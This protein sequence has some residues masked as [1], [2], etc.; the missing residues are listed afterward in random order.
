MNSIPYN[1]RYLVGLG[2]FLLGFRMAF[3]DYG[4]A[5]LASFIAGLVICFPVLVNYFK[6][7]KTVRIS[8]PW[9]DIPTYI[10]IG[11]I[12]KGIATLACLLIVGGFQR[13][14]YKESIA[15]AVICAIILSP[16]D[17]LLFGPPDPYQP[18]RKTVRNTI[19]VSIRCAG[20]GLYLMGLYHLMEDKHTKQEVAMSL[21][22][23]G[24]VLMLMRPA[25][26]LLVPVRPPM[27]S[28]Q[29][30]IPV[31]PASAAVLTSA[32][33]PQ[34]P[35]PPA[36]D[37]DALKADYLALPEMNAQAR[38]FAFQ[39]FLHRLFT[40]HHIITR[41][42]F[43]LQGE[44]ID[45]SFDLGAQTWLLEAKWHSLP[46]PQSDLLVFNS[47]VEGKST[48]ARGIFISYTGFSADGLIAFRHGKRTSI[49]GM[50]GNDL[51][52]ILDGHISL[53]DA[54]KL[55]AMKA[56]ENNDFFVPL[57]SFL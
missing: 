37:L 30:V 52:L 40:A 5:A 25:A 55:K 26:M 7:G 43:R 22:I 29:P 10:K 9:D 47:K 16:L 44:E 31:R 57:A 8:T 34:E 13:H 21:L 6:H 46:T 53:D 18:D 42:A 32:K 15:I 56:V 19:V 49:I 1:Y 33:T 27:P 24:L 35:A 11:W 4:A 14:L 28:M 39:R 36:P 3:R 50:D 23:A 12:R 20:V 41:S 51:L 45:G 2:Y 17:S 48:W 54:I 38:G